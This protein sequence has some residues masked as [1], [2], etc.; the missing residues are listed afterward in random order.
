MKKQ[1][2]RHS[3]EFKREVIEYSLSSS[4]SIAQICREFDISPSQFYSW[5]KLILGDAESE[6]AVG[7]RTNGISQEANPPCPSAMADEIRRLRKELAKS[8]R[9][10]E[11]LKKAALILGNDPHNN[12]S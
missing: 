7:D 12:M 1:Y 2:R 9:R 5:K 10:E 3:E 4:K 6:G 8:Q 11:I